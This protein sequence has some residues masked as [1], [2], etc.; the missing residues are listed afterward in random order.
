MTKNKSPLSIKVIA[1]GNRGCN[2]LNR[3]EVL[4]KQGIK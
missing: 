1:L 4:E 2:V 3:L